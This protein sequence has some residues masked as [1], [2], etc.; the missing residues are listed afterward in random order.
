MVEEAKNIDD[1]KKLETICK[2]KRRQRMQLIQKIASEN[3]PVHKDQWKDELKQVEADLRY[4][5]RKLNPAKKNSRKG[6]SQ[7]KAPIRDTK[8][9]LLYDI[10][11]GL[12]YI[13]QVDSF[14]KRFGNAASHVLAF[15]IH[16]E[17][18]YGQRW[19]LHRLLKKIDD[20]RKNPSRVPGEMMLYEFVFDA[21]FLGQNFDKLWRQLAE[22]IFPEDFPLLKKIYEELRPRLSAGLPEDTKQKIIDRVHELLETTSVILFFD[23]LTNV[24]KTDVKEYLK[25]FVQKF[26]LPLTEMASSKPPRNYL[27]LFLV[28]HQGQINDENPLFENQQNC[29]S[30]SCT[31]IELSKLSKFYEDE[32]TYWMNYSKDKLFQLRGESTLEVQHIMKE[33]GGI[34]EYVFL[35]ICEQCSYDW[36]LKQQKWISK[37]LRAARLEEQ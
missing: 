21:N 13:K 24:N 16:G 17:E 25:N 37:Y 36:F 12:N 14:E 10:L 3:N 6:Q 29:A 28:E 35:H 5:E 27:F 4:F 34:P 8:E 30:D 26:W 32:L 15:L 23:R 20:I 2:K 18:M 1:H 33:S 9:E 11:L 31:P 19:L 22:R 7:V